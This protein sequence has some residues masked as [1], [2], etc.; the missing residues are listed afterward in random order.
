MSKKGFTLV[1]VLAVVL[2]IGIL[3]VIALP[4][5]RN[6]TERA[7]IQ[8]A[9][10][11]LRIIFDASERLAAANGYKNFSSFARA[12]QAEYKEAGKGNYP[13]FQK[14]GIFDDDEFSHCDKLNATISLSCKE[15]VFTVAP[16]TG[17]Y[18]YV[19]MYHS[20]K[21]GTDFANLLSIKLYRTNPP[22]LTCGKYN[23]SGDQSGA[24]RKKCEIYGI[25]SD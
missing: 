15:E 16:Q 17:D 2:I 3:T 18:G 12:K 14:M 24:I 8:G 25:D 9:I 21:V 6:I 1:E 23:N 22:R 7:K 10:T 20:G 19:E 11:R 5:Y 13:F 4:Q